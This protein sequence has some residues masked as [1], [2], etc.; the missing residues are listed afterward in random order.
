MEKIEEIISLIDSHEKKETKNVFLKYIKKWPWFV[1]LCALGVAAGYYIYLNS[2]NTYKVQSRILIKKDDNSL[3]AVFSSNN[4]IMAMGKKAN[5]ENQIGILKSYTL[6]RK[7]LKNLNWETSWYR[8]ELLYDAELYKQPPFELKVP[9]NGINAQ[10]TTIEI[11]ALNDRKYSI[12]AEGTT[13]QNGP[14]QTIAIETTQKFGE[15]YYNEFFNF[16]ITKGDGKTGQKY[17]LRFNDIN[18]LTTQYLAKTKIELV[19][20]NSD[21]ISIS[22]EGEKPYKEA[23]FIN[24][25]NR[26]FIDFGMENKNENSENS[27]KFIDSQLARIK[28][29]LGTAE[30]KFSNYRKNNQVMNLGQEAQL[31]YEKLEEI[32]QEQYLTQLQIDY[33]TDLQQYLDNS[34]K[35]EEMVNPSV[36]G[37]TDQNLNGMLAKLMD[38]YSRREVLSYSVQDKNPTLIVIEK[39]IKVT[40]DG[41]EETLK[42]QLKA[43]IS[44]KESMQERY[45]SIQSRLKKLPETEKKLIGIQREFDLNNELYTYMLQKKAEASITKASIAPEVQVIDEALVEAAVQTGPN[46]VKNVGAGFVGGFAIPFIIIT[47]LSFFNNKIETR[48]EIEKESRIPVLDGIIQHKYKVKLPVIHHP[49]SGIAESFRG[50]KSNLNAIL[51]RPGSKVVSINSLIPGEGKSFISSNFSAI[52]TKTKKKVLLIGADLHKPTLHNYLG[53]DETDGLSNYFAG[54]KSYEE[55]LSATSIENLYFIQAGPI[56]KNPSDLI[57]SVKFENLINR[58]RKVFDYIIIDNAPLLLVP[59]AV[60]TSRFSDV[61][62]FILRINHSHKEQIKQINKTVE[63][64]KIERSAIL[65][66][67]APDRGYGYG[68]KYWKKGYGEYKHK[69]SIA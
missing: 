42:N 17:L 6:Y 50:V 59:D 22:I 3:S 61:S 13:H 16:T 30:E 69:M 27:V 18:T 65:I 66:N 31:I 25:L 37:I 21:L 29:S 19:D 55:I 56:P 52:L 26:V 62:L 51:E 41:L 57:D 28:S 63:F 54:E 47:L 2:P 68:N 24:E 39:E 35:I 23:D 20:L 32:E 46:M 36:I 43:T 4:P 67:E 10:N 12:K 9:P 8:K 34:K 48:E 60:L 15:P 11:I 64:N 1:V 58:A 53:V 49:R 33:Y 45:T 7:A 44:K 5:I 40:R 14:L 38:L